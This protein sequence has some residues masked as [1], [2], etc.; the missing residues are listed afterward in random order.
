MTEICFYN[1]YVTEFKLNCI[2]GGGYKVEVKM[3]GKISKSN[4]GIRDFLLIILKCEFM[5]HNKKEKVDVIWL[6]G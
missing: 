2:G 1:T 5:F 3:R 4:L 6:M